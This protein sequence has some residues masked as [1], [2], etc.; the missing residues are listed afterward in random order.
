[1]TRRR[2][3]LIIA[4]VLLAVLLALLTV[5]YINYRAT[6][7]IGFDLR[8][9]ASATITQPEYLYSFGSDGVD[10]LQRPLGVL[11]DGNNVYVT[12][13]QRGDITE[14]TLDGKRVKTIGKGNLLV[15]LY[16]AKHPKTGEY[17]VSDRRLRSIEIFDKNGKWLRTFNPDLPKDQLPTFPTGKIQ[18]APV[19][20]AFAPDG[21]LYVSELLN[22]HR[23]LIFDPSGKFVKSIGAAGMVETAD[24]APDAFMFP[25]SIKVLGN[26]VW[27][28]DSNNRRIKVYSRD[29]EFKRFVITQGLPRGIT[30]LPKRGDE[31][32][33][34]VVVDTLAM[35]A[36]IWDAAKG[37]KILSFGE[38]G[39]L[40]GQFAYPNDISTDGVRRMFI[41]DTS[42][43]RVQVWGWP[44]EAAPIPTP[45]TPLQWL[46]CLSPL[47]LLPL[48]LLLRRKRFFATEDFVNAMVAA[49]EVNLMANRRWRWEVTAEDYEKLS[50]ITQG[51]IKLEDLLHEADY[52][53]SDAQ[54]LMERFELDHTSAVRLTIARR[55]KIFCTEDA[56]LRRLAR[57]L[58][59]DVVNRIE[60][61]ERFAR[62]NQASEIAPGAGGD[63]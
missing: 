19:A 63:A 41:T 35:D 59:I 10:R 21:T 52:S 27:V 11:V 15:P 23:L 55:A 25:N 58:E 24:A 60:F 51:D 6:R 30:F 7:S 4:L 53:E 56:E 12:D 54:A 1:V 62:R 32:R 28:A 34:L 26:E 29:G 36:T 8:L 3:R 16:I 57:V 17:W 14:Y 42:N 40:E 22:G 38:R 49:E 43:G 37:E 46:I 45:Q 20:L 48:L 61:L 13:S 2:K 50:G 18:W 47:L 39:V 31:P 5:A 44:A 33:A 9:D